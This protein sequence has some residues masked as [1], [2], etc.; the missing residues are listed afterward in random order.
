MKKCPTCKMTVDAKNECPICGATLT[1]EP[2][3]DADKEHI[4]LNKYYLVYLA[5][6]VWFS[7][8]CTI[9]CVIRVLIAKPQPSPLLYGMVGLLIISVLV[10]LFQQKVAN[11]IRW[12][13]MSDEYTIF[14]TYLWK[15]LFAGIA[16][17]FAFFIK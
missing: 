13:Y 12:K 2:F 16:V 10:S 9:V 6:A 7:L 11:A 14:K 15:Y 17:V 3:V 5:K 1:Y 4:I 8:L